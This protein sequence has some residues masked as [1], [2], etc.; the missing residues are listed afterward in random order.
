MLPYKV[1]ERPFDGFSISYG[2]RY[3]LWGPIDDVSFE[4]VDAGSIPAR[5]GVKSGDRLIRIDGASVKGM[6]R[7]EFE[8]RLFRTKAVLVLEVQ[9]PGSK[10]VRKLELQFDPD[11]WEQTDR[12]RS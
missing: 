2:V 11:S 6:K 9:S 8:L 7:R 4:S 1:A 12:A 3:L 10:E 5:R